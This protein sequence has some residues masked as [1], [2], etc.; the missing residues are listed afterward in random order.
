MCKA[1]DRLVVPRSV[2]FAEH[3][4]L[5]VERLAEMWAVSFGGALHGEPDDLLNFGVVVE[6]NLIAAVKT[7]LGVGFRSR[8]CDR[9]AGGCTFDKITTFHG[10]SFC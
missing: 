3:L 2:D 8:R 1:L 10:I 5:V 6:V 7:R 4:R 9:A